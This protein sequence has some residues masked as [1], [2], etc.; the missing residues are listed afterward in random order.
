MSEKKPSKVDLFLELAQP[1]NQGFSKD[2]PVSQ[3]VG[4]YSRLQFGN[5][6]DWARDDGTLGRK[7]NVVRHK[8]GPTQA[9]TSVELQ[10]YNKN[11]KKRS[12]SK[13]VYDAIRGKRCVVLATTSKVLPDHKDGRYDDPRVSRTSDQKLEDF[14]PMSESVNYAKREHCKKCRQTNKRF[15]A[16]QLGYPVGQ[17]KGNG[18]YRGTCVG[19]YWFSPFAFNQ[20]LHFLNKT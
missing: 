8:R 20:A 10:G 19:C 15:D 14:Q 13:K 5:G 2:V 6:A 12:I 18:T 17:V 4:K 11:P 3:F 16:K 1:D 7:Y 9:I